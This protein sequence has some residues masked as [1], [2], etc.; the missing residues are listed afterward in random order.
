MKAIAID[1]FGGADVVKVVDMPIPEPL[2][3]EVQ[4]AVAYAAVN[5]VDWKVREGLLKDRM[6]YQ[7]PIILGW[8]VSGKIS[9][10]G[11]DVT[12]LKVG[13]EVFTYARKP[14]VQAG[15]YAEY[16]CF[17]AQHVVLKP[18]KLS[19]KEAAAVPL[20][21]LTAWQS[22]IEWGQIQSGE[23]VL[24]HAGAGGVGGFAIQ[25]AKLHGA[26]MYPQRVL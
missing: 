24:I 5:P 15:T 9:K 2:P 23:T 14:I 10:I 3:N 11:K 12:N 1:Q 17:D 19:L 7:F 4:I 22:V 25:F 20:I 21:S 8:D 16:V 13:D 6:P 26:H 18:R